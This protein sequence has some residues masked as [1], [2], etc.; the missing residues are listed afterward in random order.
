[1]IWDRWNSDRTLGKKAGL[2]R[3]TT[4]DPSREKWSSLI[5]LAEGMAKRK[6]VF[7]ASHFRST[8]SRGSK[9]GYRQASSLRLVPEDPYWML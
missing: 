4:F 9:G 2:E 7:R 5:L 3:I 8:L 1:M 6:A